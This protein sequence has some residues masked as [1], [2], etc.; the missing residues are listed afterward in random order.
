MI[1]Q[2]ASQVTLGNVAS[3]VMLTL[4]KHQRVPLAP[5]PVD[6][7]FLVNAG[8]VLVEAR[9]P[10]RPRQVLEILYPEDVFFAQDAPEALGA[11]LIAATPAELQRFR[12]DTVDK[13]ER[14]DPSFANRIAAATTLRGARRTLHLTSMSGHSGEERLADF[15]VEIGTFLGRAG[16]AG[17]SFELPLTREEIADYLALNPDTLSRIFSR[18]KS[19]GLIAISRGRA[20]VPDWDALAR[21]SP[22]AGAISALRPKQTMVA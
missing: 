6:H 4:R 11:A 5:A 9:L 13:L 18:L 22:L 3:G 2:P 20:T 10:D 15:L 7:V 16:S 19:T 14:S 1:D 21:L 8:V 12:T 17:R